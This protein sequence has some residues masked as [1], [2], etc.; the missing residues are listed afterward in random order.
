ML[1]EGLSFVE[2]FVIIYGTDPLLQNII[3]TFAS[4]DSPSISITITPV[5]NAELRAPIFKNYSCFP[6]VLSLKRFSDPPLL[7]I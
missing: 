6:H 4:V 5:D 1:I 7:T 2:T 3:T